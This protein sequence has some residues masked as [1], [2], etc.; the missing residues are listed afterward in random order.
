[1]RLRK[2][3]IGAH[4]VG[5]GLRRNPS[6]WGHPCSQVDMAPGAG[7]HIRLRTRRH[8]HTPSYE[9]PWQ[10]GEGG[11]VITRA[12]VCRLCALLVCL[13]A[14]P[15]MGSPG[16]GETQAIAL[17]PTHP[18]IIYV[19]AAKGLC[20]TTRGGKDNWPSTGLANLGP[21]NIVLDP[22][23]PD[24]IYTGTYEMGVYKSADAAGSW[25]AGQ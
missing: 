8:A 4:G 1:M 15:Q 22:S 20:K 5:R 2:S 16:G 3:L 6:R 11:G 10:R 23:N 13:P 25:A 24:V 9:F 14:Y 12:M 17:H 19:G 21:R 18:E 7:V